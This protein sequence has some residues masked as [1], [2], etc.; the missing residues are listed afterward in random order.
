MGMMPDVTNSKRDWWE[1]EYGK[2]SLWTIKDSLVPG[3]SNQAW[4][5]Q[6]QPINQPNERKRKDN[7]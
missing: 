1:C 5:K 4:F 3:N 6:N 7:A 2:Y